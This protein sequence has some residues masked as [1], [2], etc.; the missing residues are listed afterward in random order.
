MAKTAPG[1]AEAPL[2]RRK[3]EQQLGLGTNSTQS[4]VLPIPA[5]LRSK[6]HSRG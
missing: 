5:L 4:F 6:L 1:E 2:L 3:L